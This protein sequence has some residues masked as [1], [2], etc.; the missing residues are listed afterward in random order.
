MNQNINNNAITTPL[1]NYLYIIQYQQA[2]IQNINNIQH[3]VKEESQKEVQII[4][5]R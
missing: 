5:L 4:N 3:S 1:T 2:M